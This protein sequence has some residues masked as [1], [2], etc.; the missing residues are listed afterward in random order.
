M[1]GRAQ[2]G[3]VDVLLSNPGQDEL[4]AICPCHIEPQ[5][6]TLPGAAIR[7][8]REKPS[9]DEITRMTGGGKRI[10]EIR[11]NL[12]TADADAGANCRS[13]VR[14]VDAQ[15]IAEGLDRDSRCARGCAAPPCVNGGH[16]AR[17]CI[18]EQQGDAIGCPHG[19]R[20]AGMIRDEDVGFR[21]FDRKRPSTTDHDGTI[22]VHLSERHDC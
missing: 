11:P 21:P 13:H 17:S 10:D 22:T 18:R 6:R 3:H 4:I 7:R 9:I 16:G 2:P 19:N 15:L 12:V 5:R 1:H 20:R 14:R 8:P